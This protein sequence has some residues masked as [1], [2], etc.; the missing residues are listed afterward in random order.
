MEARREGA[1]G[2]GTWIVVS[3]LLIA[4]QHKHHQHHPTRSISP[5]PRTPFRIASHSHT[6]FPSHNPPKIALGFP[7]AYL[8]DLVVAVG[9]RLDQ[10]RQQRRQLREHRR[11][12]LHRHA[13]VSVDM[14]ERD[15]TCSSER[16]GSLSWAGGDDGDSE[17]RMVDGC[18]GHAWE[19][20]DA[21][22]VGERSWWM[23]E[24]RVG[25]ASVGE[26]AMRLSGRGER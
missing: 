20:G 7:T 4:C 23:G 18:E 8:D 16:R 24:A 13:R 5:R 19:R 1:E 21:M 11:P 6:H 17:R 25:K 22:G 2:S 12:H 9:V 10:Q 3:T 26:E 15:P 14:S